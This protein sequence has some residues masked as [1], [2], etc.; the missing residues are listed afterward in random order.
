[1]LSGVSMTADAPKVI[2]PVEIPSNATFD[3]GGCGGGNGG[4]APDG[5]RLALWRLAAGEPGGDR[6]E[7]AGAGKRIGSVR[8][9]IKV[10]QLFPACG[11]LYRLV[12]VLPKGGIVIDRSPVAP[13]RGVTLRPDSLVIPM[14]GTGEVGTSTVTV[15]AIAAAGKRPTA[16][17]AVKEVAFARGTDQPP[18]SSATRKVQVAGGDSLEVLGSRYTVLAVVPPDPANRLPGWVELAS[19]GPS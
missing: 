8:A 7:S 5:A 13:P 1:M 6:G 12:G 16:S 9:F 17:L 18:T 3:L 10:G 2:D 19:A 4:A 14:Q 15:D 11:K